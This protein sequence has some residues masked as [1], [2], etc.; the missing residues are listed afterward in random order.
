M[1]D[2]E[3]FIRENLPLTP[4]PHIPEIRLHLAQPSSRPVAARRRGSR[5]ALAL[6]G[7]RLGRRRSRSPATFSTIRNWSRGK[8]VLDIGS[9]SGL[10]AIAAKLAGAARVIAAETDPFGIAAIRIN[11]EANGVELATTGTDLTEVAPPTDIDLVLAGDVFY[12]KDV[13]RRM[14]AFL[15]ACRAAG[16]GALVGD[17]HR[18]DLPQTGLHCVATYSVADFGAAVGAVVP[19]AV[20]TLAS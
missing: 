12:D 1:L 20:F 13:A 4:V 7:L 18:A 10:V 14:M 15:G 17:P 11:A 16:I 3:R 6:L 9:G 8:A 19:A 2:P 5:A